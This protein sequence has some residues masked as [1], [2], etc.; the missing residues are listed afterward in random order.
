MVAQLNS[1]KGGAVEASLKLAKARYDNHLSLYSSRSLRRVFAKLIEFFEGMSSMLENTP[2]EEV[3]FHASYNKASAK[4]VL[5]A[6]P[7]R[8]VRK[9]LEMV[10][11]RVQKHFSEDKA[12][13]QVVWR[14]LQDEFLKDSSVFAE[15]IQKVYPGTDVQLG[16]SVADA[17]ACFGEIAK[18]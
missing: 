13:Q 1:I 11:V 15:W 14:S 4:R 7:I 8:E 9:N 10:H 5:Q 18:R 16:Y 3:A 2:P 6:F 12:L 17:M